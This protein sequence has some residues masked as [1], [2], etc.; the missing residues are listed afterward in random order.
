[1]AAALGHEVAEVPQDL[2]ADLFVD[3]IAGFL[4]IGLEN[5]IEVA[6]VVLELQEP[7]HVVDAGGQEIDLVFGDV[8][9]TR[10]QIHRRLH[11]VAEADEAEPG[12]PAQGPAAH[13]HGIGVVEEEDVGT[14]LPHIIGD[15]EKR[16]D[17]AQ[18]TKHAARPQG[19]ADALVDAETERDFVVLP[20]LLDASGLDHHDHVIR[21]AQRLAAV[22]GGDGRGVHAVVLDHAV[23]ERMHF[24]QPG[25][26]QR[27]Q[28]VFAAGQRRR[29]QH[30][31]H[32][33]FAENQ[34]A[35]T[36]HRDLGHDVASLIPRRWVIPRKNISP[37]APRSQKRKAGDSVRGED[38]AHGNPPDSAL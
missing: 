35:R 18:R 1:V 4:E 7:G 12:N 34:A 37:A 2:A 38:S 3:V 16:G 15:V 32:Q 6:A 25:A 33:G 23:D 26:R 10:D 17:V 13:G 22:G 24:I 36:D 19:V 9:V 31:R 21:A 11:T 14:K 29:R 27:H 8:Y 5:R 20:K 30:I 28:P